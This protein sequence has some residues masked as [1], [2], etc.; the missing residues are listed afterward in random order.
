MIESCYK[1]NN[2]IL[3]DGQLIVQRRIIGFILQGT[4]RLLYNSD[5][6][7]NDS[8]LIL[9]STIYVHFKM[10]SSYMRYYDNTFYVN[11]F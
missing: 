3:N 4:A 1:T 11:S 2:N 7:G 10:I 9:H 5:Q 8:Q 6:R